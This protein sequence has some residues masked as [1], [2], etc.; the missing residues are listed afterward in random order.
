MTYE[1]L[2]GQKPYHAGTAQE[3]LA[4]HVNDP[5]PVLPAPHEHLQP[6][7]GRM[8]AKDRGQR[9]PSASALLD[10]LRQRGI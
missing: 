3:L 2:T 7:L 10:D 5:V 6:V 9:Y 8:M 1:M 4:K